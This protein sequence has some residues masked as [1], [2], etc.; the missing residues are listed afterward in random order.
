MAKFSKYVLNTIEW[1]G[2]AN[3]E[4]TDP[5]AAAIDVTGDP[6]AGLGGPYKLL[7]NPTQNSAADE[8]IEYPFTLTINDPNGYFISSGLIVE[9]N[10]QDTG[11]AI[12]RSTSTGQTFTTASGKI[13]CEFLG[14]DEWIA[15]D[16]YLVTTAGPVG[17]TGV[18]GPQGDIGATGI[19]GPQ[20]ETGATG[21]QGPQ[22]DIGST[23]V[24]G[25]QG[26]P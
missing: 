10:S 20:G 9:P 21:V 4:L 11:V 5:N 6:N 12:N 15:Y 14:N 13:V 2:T 18:Q 17:A 3:L 8:N 19:Q 16:P 25:P 7:L 22:G 23:G 1:D 26:G 24:Q